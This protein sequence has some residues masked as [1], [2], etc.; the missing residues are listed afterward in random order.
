MGEARRRGAARQATV[1]GERP[2][3]DW[4]RDDL[5]TGGDFGLLPGRA[6]RLA[7]EAVRQGVTLVV[8]LRIEDDDA[9]LWHGTGVRYLRVGTDDAEGHHIPAGLFDEVV[10]AVR[11]ATAAGGRSLVHC[12]MGVNRGPSAAYAVL[13]DRGHGPVQ[14]WNLIRRARPQAAI[15]YAMDALLADQARRPTRTV[16]RGRRAGQ[17]VP[18]DT[19]DEARRL[20]AAMERTWTDEFDGYVQ[21]VIAQHRRRDQLELRQVLSGDVDW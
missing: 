1:D 15:Y 4:V 6:R 19:D 2:G 7:D 16:T 8:D 10:A 13:L 9:D 3:W 5:A 14:A 11:T 17:Q 20:R 21:H 12:H 18:R